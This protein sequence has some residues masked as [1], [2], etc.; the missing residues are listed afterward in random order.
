MKFK[1]M[2]FNEEIKSEKIY[3]RLSEV[4][5]DMNYFKELLASESANIR[6]LFER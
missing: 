2:K 5:H 1:I 6:E 4:T 3:V